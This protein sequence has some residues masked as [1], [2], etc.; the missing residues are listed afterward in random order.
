MQ[1]KSILNCV[2]NVVT[3]WRCKN[4]MSTD[5]SRLLRD[6]PRPSGSSELPPTGPNVDD[7]SSS[8][9]VTTVTAFLADSW[10]DT[11]D[12][13][14]AS[15]HSTEQ[16]RQIDPLMQK[17]YLFSIP[18]LLLFCLA[19]VIVNT[20]IVVSIRWIRRPLSPTLSFSVSL[21][22]AD[23]YAS[24]VVGIGLVINSLL[25]VGLGVTPGR[26]DACYALTLE[27]FR[28]GGIIVTV[29]HLTALAINHYIGILRPLHYAS[30]M[31]PRTTI[32]CIAL[33][34]ILPIF[35]FFTYFSAVEDQGFRSPLCQNYFFLTRKKFRIIFSVLFFGPLIIMGVIYIH[36]FIIVKRHQASRLRFQNSQQLARSVKAI[37]TTV[38][39]LGTYI[40]GWIPAVLLYCLVCA[41]CMYSFKAADPITMFALYTTCNFLYI[42]KTLVDPVIYAARMH[43][44]KMAVRRMRLF[45]CHCCPG[46]VSGELR[47]T[48]ELSAHR[49]SLYMTRNRRL[50]AAN[51][52]DTSVCRFQSLRNNNG[53]V[54]SCGNNLIVAVPPNNNSFLHRASVNSTAWHRGRANQGKNGEEPEVQHNSTLI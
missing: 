29:G 42:L 14:E 22:L 27:A 47:V 44:I 26:N 6:L 45:C 4:A 30:T 23:A 41:D 54:R 49:L 53:S 51:G 50:S 46:S 15:N 25:P 2:Y 31:T 10:N 13:P 17:L 48:S 52:A 33:L 40:V 43:E 28:L 5:T 32:V 9:V 8:S 21:A 35:F 36:I 7:W 16:P 12:V 34:W 18:P 38:L 3:G 39:I 24:L 20:V 37:K 1:L 11:D 19:T